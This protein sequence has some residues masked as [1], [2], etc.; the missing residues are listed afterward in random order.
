MSRRG[1][2]KVYDGRTGKKIRAIDAVYDG[3]IDGLIV[4]RG[5]RDRPHPLN[6]RFVPGVDRA[7]L[8]HQRPE[9]GRFTTTINV[10][11]E[12]NTNLWQR[13]PLPTVAVTSGGG[14]LELYTA[15]YGYG[16]EGWG[17]EGYGGW[18]DLEEIGF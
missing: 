12:A 13:D 18:G 2:M 1:A 15:L 11:F 14:T 17:D 4:T 10:G 7:M 6:R 16:E 5:E 8:L 9:T 3:E